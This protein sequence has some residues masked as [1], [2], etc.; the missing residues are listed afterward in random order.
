MLFLSSTVLFLNQCGFLSV[1]NCQKTA[2]NGFLLPF[3]LGM[4][5]VIILVVNTVITVGAQNKYLM[6]KSL[7][8]SC[9]MSKRVVVSAC[10]CCSSF[11][12]FHIF[13]YIV[14]FFEKVVLDMLNIFAL[15]EWH[16]CNFGMN[17]LFGALLTLWC[18]PENSH[19]KCWLP[20]QF[21][22]MPLSSIQ[23]N[24]T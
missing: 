8:Q 4:M 21:L 9:S 1:S 12:V 17:G 13:S 18:T 23:L 3:L 22:Q 14:F 11:S 24:M 19:I 7:L 2:Q 16:I 5:T 15:I 10:D 20:K 6:T